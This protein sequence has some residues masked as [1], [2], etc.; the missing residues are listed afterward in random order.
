MTVTYFWPLLLLGSAAGEAAGERLPGAA[1]NCQ[2]LLGG[3]QVLL[4]AARSCQE[5]LGAPGVPR[6]CQGLLGAA[7]I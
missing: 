3:C 6:S 7:R 2:E 4:G 5:L 1:R